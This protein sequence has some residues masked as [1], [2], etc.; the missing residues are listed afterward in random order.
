MNIGIVKGLKVG[1]GHGGLFGA[2]FMAYAL[3]F[4]Y[5]AVLVARDIEDGCREGGDDDCLSGGTILTVFFCVIMGSIAIGQIAPPFGALTS[6]RV[7][8][9]QILKLTRR[10]PEID[11]L[12]TEGFIPG[13]SATGNIEFSNIDFSYPSRPDMKICTNYNLSIKPGETIA[14]CGSSGSGKSTVANLLLRFYD[15]TGGVVTLD[16]KNIKDLNVRWLRSQIGFVGQEPVLFAGT[17]ADNILGGM[18]MDLER[19]RRRNSAASHPESNSTDELY[20]PEELRERVIAASKQAN[21]HEFISSFPDGYD[22]D[23]GSSGLSMSGGQKQRIAI[24]RALIK[25][26]AILILDEATSALDS[27]S[28]RVVQEAIDALQSS[29]ARTCITIAHRLSTIRNAD[30]IAVV[31]AGHVVELGSH[32]ELMENPD[33]KYRKLVTMQMATDENS[34]VDGDGDEDDLALIA[35]K[36]VAADLSGAEADGVI[37]KRAPSLVSSVSDS[38]SIVGADEAETAEILK[39]ATSKRMWA[40]VMNYPGWTFLA[41]TA[42]MCFGAVFPVWGLFLAKAQ[43][44]FFLDDPHDIRVRSAE[45]SIYFIILGGVSLLSAMLMYWGV[46]QV[47]ERVAAELRSSLFESLLRREV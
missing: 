23:V 34:A 47:G 18:D 22:T 26:P 41:V 37:R 21:A 25:Q 20:T 45:T 31:D 16:G 33:S 9:A 11:G 1:I 2:C 12:S 13:S 7:A 5:G 27:A 32:D 28:E 46:A 30:K 40:L 15:P 35:D 6:A 29:K 4:W 19:L 36:T 24:A 8:T 10:V 3:G 43:T 38:E 44:N 17:I 42:A 14:L 39:K